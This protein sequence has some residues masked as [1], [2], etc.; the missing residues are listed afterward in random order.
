[1]VKLEEIR[2]NEKSYIYSLSTNG[3][4]CT[5]LIKPMKITLRDGKDAAP[6]IS[7]VTLATSWVDMLVSSQKVKT[8]LANE[9]QQKSRYHVTATHTVMSQLEKTYEAVPKYHLTDTKCG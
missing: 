5:A 8:S 7:A 6:D 3:T 4:Y 2:G 1:M 9:A